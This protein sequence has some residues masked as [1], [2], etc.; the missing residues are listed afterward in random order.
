MGGQALRGVRAR[1]ATPS[2]SRRLPRTPRWSTTV[3]AVRIMPKHVLEGPFKAGNFASAYNVSTPPDKLVTSGAVAGRRS[4]LPGE[5]TVLG[6]N[7]YWFGVD[8]AE[9]AAAVSRRD[10]F[11]DR[12]RSRCGRFEVSSRRAARP[13]QREAGELPLVP[14]QPAEGQLHALRSRPR[15]EHEL[16]LVQP[17]QGPRSRRRERRSA[18]RLSIRSSTR[19]SAIRC[20]AARCRWPSIATR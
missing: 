16:F 1:S 14:G 8:Q 5:K 20:S 15:S 17:E 19:G 10:R 13:R 7:P 11:L 6:R 3:G 2:S 18:S 4:T 9:S 12:A